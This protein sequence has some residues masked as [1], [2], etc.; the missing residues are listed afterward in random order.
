M[1]STEYTLIAGAVAAI[2]GLSLN[3]FDRYWQWYRKN[4]PQP[5]G[6]V[7][8]GEDALRK[9]ENEYKRKLWN[10]RI[11]RLLEVLFLVGFVAGIWV[12]VQQ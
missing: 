7:I 5:P 10:Y 1:S 3:L 8:G 2:G 9:A 11:T 12:I 4:R 6:S